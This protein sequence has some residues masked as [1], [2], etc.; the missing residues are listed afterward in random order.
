MFK[1]KRCNIAWKSK[2]YIQIFV[3]VLLHDK[4]KKKWNRI[5][6]IVSLEQKLVYVQYSNAQNF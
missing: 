1:Y 3:D 6:N 2:E 4:A 5:I